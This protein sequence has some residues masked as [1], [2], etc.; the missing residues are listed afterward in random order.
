LEQVVKHAQLELLHVLQP[1]LPLLAELVIS[2]LADI[3]Y[4]ALLMLKVVDLLSMQLH[5][6]MDI[7]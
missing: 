1:M 7:S 5:V 3:V 2:Y 4:H 6:Q